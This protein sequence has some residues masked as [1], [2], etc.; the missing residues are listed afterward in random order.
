VLRSQ[1]GNI[2][3]NI[4]YNCGARGHTA[5]ACLDLAKA[6]KCFVCRAF[7]HKSPK[8]PNKGANNDNQD[9]ANGS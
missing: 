9:N 8:C 3:P 5:K 1:D 6:A 2:S 7:G 4:C